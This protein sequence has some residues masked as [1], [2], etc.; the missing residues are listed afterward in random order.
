MLRSVTHVSD[1]RLQISEQW[2]QKL[3][4]FLH[5]GLIVEHLLHLLVLALI[6][7][8]GQLLQLLLVLAIVEHGLRYGHI[9]VNLRVQ[10]R[11][12]RPLPHRLYLHRVKH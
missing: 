5:A 10:V 3:V 8:D 7:I 4:L 1:L 12:C 6:S 2:L 9:S 11:K